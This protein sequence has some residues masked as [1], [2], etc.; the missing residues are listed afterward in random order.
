[1]KTMIIF[2]NPAT[3]SN[4]NLVHIATKITNKYNFVISRDKCYSL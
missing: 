2:N 3:F 1:M 4:V